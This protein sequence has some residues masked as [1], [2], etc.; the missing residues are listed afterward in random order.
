MA[1]GLNGFYQNITIT[2]P[3]AAERK[4]NL[5]NKQ[6]PRIW[7]FKASSNLSG[8]WRQIPA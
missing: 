2:V 4:G 8:I 7:S 5:K 3:V 1:K 6:I